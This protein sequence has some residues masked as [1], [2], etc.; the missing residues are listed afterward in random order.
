MT[1]AYQN[2]RIAPE[3]VE[4]IAVL[5]QQEIAATFPTIDRDTYAS[6]G[7]YREALIKQY[8]ALRQKEFEYTVKDE[9]LMGYLIPAQGNI[10]AQQRCHNL[11]TWRGFPELKD[12]TL[13][14]DSCYSRVTE[15]VSKSHSNPGPNGGNCCAISSNALIAQISGEM[16]YD[17]E[18]NLIQPKPRQEAQNNPNGAA[19]I[20]RLDSIPEQYRISPQKLRQAYP[21]GV[22]LNTAIKDGV[23]KAGD[24][25][26]IKTGTPENGGTGC[27]AMVIAGVQKNESGQVIGYD[28]QCNNPPCLKHIDA[29]NP[30]YYGSKP[31]N[32]AVRV[33]DWINDKIKAEATAEM[34][35]EEL[36]K[37][38]SERKEI[39]SEKIN[40]M[41][42]HEQTLIADGRCTVT[43][44]VKGRAL[45][46]I[47]GYCA[48]YNAQEASL[49]AEI[50]AAS[51]SLP[52]ADRETLKKD[53]KA[54][55]G[56]LPQS[57]YAELKSAHF[58]RQVD[59]R[60]HQA[61]Q[62]EEHQVARAEN[63]QPARA[64]EQHEPQTQNPRVIVIKPSNDHT[65]TTI[66]LEQLEAR[67]RR[68]SGR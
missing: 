44:Y 67:N 9:T 64:E 37:M 14:A 60:Q 5:R 4:R 3:T 59:A 20:E 26:S 33:N 24:E 68:N 41:K 29:R 2:S 45:N 30:D 13:V 11:E 25:I 43:H 62:T 65:I 15:I 61:F 42:E 40:K 56:A 31:L 21:E 48:Q 19:W 63:R 53:L 54:Q 57:P 47:D 12:Q 17:D 49:Q 35:T 1:N 46:N 23:I 18:Q 34:P 66:T 50:A 36:E 51:A 28:L 32:S 52:V 39:L 38:V 55:T 16:G 10:A 58:D 6:E 8:Q 22:T 27:H 7:E